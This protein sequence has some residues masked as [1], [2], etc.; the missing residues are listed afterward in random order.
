[1]SR[2]DVP[3]YLRLQ[4]DYCGRLGSPMY[5][6]LL[7]RAAE[8]A[9]AGG[10]IA[11]VLDG[12]PHEPIASAMALRLMGAVHRLVLEGRVPTLAAHYPS[13]GGDGDAD[14]AWPAFRAFV[15][16]ET[17]ELRRRLEQGVQTNEVGR[18][19]A[20]ICG[21]LEVARATGLGLRCLE[22]G[23]SAGLNLRWDHFRYE[24]S[25][26]TWGDASSPVVL[27][28]YPAQAP[29]FDVAARVVERAGCDPH[30]LD[31]TSDDGRLTL[32]S[33]VWPDQAER[34]AL[35][36]A[37]CE[38]AR[39][40]PAHVERA[41]APDWL[42]E[43][44]AVA[45][46]RR[47]DR[48]VP[49]DHVPVPRSAEPRSRCR[50]A[51]RGGRPRDAA[52]AVRL[53]PHGAGRRAGRSATHALARRHGAARRLHQL[54]RPQRPSDRV[55][56]TRLTRAGSAREKARPM[57]RRLREWYGNA[58]I[59]WLNACLLF[60]ALNVAVAVVHW[61]TR[62]PA[63][64][65]LKPMRPA[66][67]RVYPQLDAAAIDQ[68]VAESDRPLDYEPY[69]DMTDRPARGR[70]VNVDAA[71]FR[72]SAA[73]APW[74]PDAQRHV[75][76]VF[77]GSTTFGY[78]VTDADTIPSYLQPML[79]ADGGRPVSVYNF[80]HSG[81]YSTQERILFER[82]VV[83]GHRPDTAVFIDGLNDFVSADDLPLTA[84]RLGPGYALT[85]EPPLRTALRVLPITTT[86]L[87]LGRALGVVTAPPSPETSR[88]D[89]DAV[90]ARYRRSKATIAAVGAAHGVRTV[91]V[92]QPVPTYKFPPGDGDRWSFGPATPLVRDA[93]PRMAT[94]HAAGELG[95]DF[96]WCAD[97]A[98]DGTESF[99]VDL[100]HYAPV[101]CERIA[102]CIADG[103]ALARRGAVP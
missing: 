16:A 5:E 89:A 67:A 3:A 13:A 63:L 9:E 12:Y 39:R 103:L 21:F 65:P 62:P 26:A 57:L 51:R 80:G 55:A 14:R 29:P 22:I 79:A 31:P 46:R 56:V 17:A 15:A 84:G 82:L 85:E 25:G 91:F 73:Q 50:A 28:D 10:P 100:V 77:G 70:F 87:R 90:L 1:M 75:V 4:G 95:R 61:R 60:V 23:A 40:V 98:A 41:S 44:L 93:Y 92:W 38:V 94:A 24:A 27:R 76:F 69:T 52:R 64:G 7:G 34:L 88:P 58:A 99:Y 6:V 20:L 32:M 68:L 49:L 86:A 81:Y 33:Y 35:L 37:A 18:S 71:G 43:R 54:P 30:P 102:R 101:L 74:P 8:D 66:I 45:R 47:G 72:T 78:G 83:A 97:L 11:T 48:G 36:R 53:A 2:I 96:V 42:A 59:V 19:A